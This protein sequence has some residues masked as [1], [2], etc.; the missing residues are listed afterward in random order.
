MKLYYAPGACSLAPHIVAAEAGIPL[1]LERVDLGLRRTETGQDY[2]HINP[3]GYVP[4][5]QLDDGSVITEAGTLIQYLA[6]Q[7]AGGPL[8]PPPGS[9]ERYRVLEWIS[10][11]ATEL[12][13]GFGPLWN[14]KSTLEVRQAVKAR[15]L[16][17]FA[18]VDAGLARTAFLTGTTFT[19]AD[20]YLF[21]IVNWAP[22]HDIDLAPWPS[23]QS[24][25]ARVA[26]RPKVQEAMRAEGLAK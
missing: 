25:M 5:L 8:A 2:A 6:D 7:Q 19:V 11:V 14:P 20:A 3:K 22:M 21:T 4:A 18:F 24:F 10:F 12:H 17:R 13:K 23:L 26:A 15:L 1:Q 16:Q 9:M